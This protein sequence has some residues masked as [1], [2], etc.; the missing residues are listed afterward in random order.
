MTVA[1]PHAPGGSWMA[2]AAAWKATATDSSSGSRSPT[3]VIP[4]ARVVEWSD[5]FTG[6]PAGNRRPRGPRDPGTLGHD[7]GFVH[8]LV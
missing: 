3:I 5:C 8:R 1:S 7:G 4:F 6:V 2:P